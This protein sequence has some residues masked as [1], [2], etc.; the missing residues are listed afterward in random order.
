MEKQPHKHAE[1]I[2]AWADGA[3]IE[4]N[5]PFR[6]WVLAPNPSW[7]EE[8]EYRIKPEPPKS[9]VPD[10]WEGLGE[11]DGYFINV[12]S[13]V[14]KLVTPIPP[15]NENK[16]LIPTRELAE[17]MLALCQLL[18]L[19]QRTWEN[20]GEWSPEYNNCLFYGIKSNK[21]LQL[22]IVAYTTTNIILAFPTREI[23]E[24]F[25]EK[26]REL[27]QTAAPLL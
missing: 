17:A 11:I 25:F 1:L 10:S 22:K 16:N 14:S 12:N 2:K 23:A 21:I 3:E 20:L 4:I 6:G 5:N 18:Q 9:V 27:I 26:H 13:I 19:R 24:E 15:F 8:N 7:H